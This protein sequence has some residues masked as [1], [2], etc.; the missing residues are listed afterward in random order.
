M[1]WLDP[2]NIIAIAKFEKVTPSNRSD[3]IYDTASLKIEIIRVE[4]A[5]KLR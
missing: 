3:A 2:V 1:N 4:K 5:S